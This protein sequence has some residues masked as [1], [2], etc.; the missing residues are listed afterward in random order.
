MIKRTA[1]TLST[2][3]SVLVDEVIACN[4]TLRKGHPFHSECICWHS[5]FDSETDAHR[6]N[7]SKQT[8]NN[9]NYN[10][11]STNRQMKSLEI[12]FCEEKCRLN[13]SYTWWSQSVRRELILF[14]PRFECYFQCRL[15]RTICLWCLMRRLI[16]QFTVGIVAIRIKWTRRVCF[17]RQQLLR[18][19]YAAGTDSIRHSEEFNWTDSI[20]NSTSSSPFWSFKI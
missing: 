20:K 16:L 3:F 4:A 12:I 19:H 13:L 1:E 18:Q 17:H 15:I 6:T 10:Y 7:V 2:G 8:M 11:N 5:I 9:N 14:L